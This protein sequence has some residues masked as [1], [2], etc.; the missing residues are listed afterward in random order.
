MKT[1]ERIL[2]VEDEKKIARFLQLELEHEGYECTIET[3]GRA[4]LDQIV[5]G[6]FDLILLDLMLPDL[7]GLMICERAR[8]V[9][10]VPILILSAKD[11]IDT[12]VQ[13]LDLGAN[14]YLT[15]PFNSREL[16]AR[17]R[18]LLRKT[19]T[20]DTSSTH[21]LTLQDMTVY[22]DR[23][24]VQIG[25]QILSLTKKE[26][27]LLTYLIRNKNVVLSRERILGEV[28][29]YDYIGDTNVVDVYI[30]YLRS[31]IDEVVGH[32]YIH[33]I[34]GIGYVIKS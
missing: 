15:K 25:D 14:D 12:K 8:Q 23:H 13:G 4:A 30:R 6:S 5:Q 26:F 10:D 33:T 19:E 16:F 32:K 18:V 24:E 28:W 2:I 11:D 27:D 7:D 31:K 17:I 22:L 1:N 9:T 21:Y 29:G 3:S 34:R 20:P